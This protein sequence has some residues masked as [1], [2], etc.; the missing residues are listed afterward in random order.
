M[1]D[2]VGRKP[3]AATLR[4][5]EKVRSVF[6]YLLAHLYPA[7]PLPQIQLP[8]SRACGCCLYSASER[9]QC[10]PRPAPAF[11]GKSCPSSSSQSQH[12]SFDWVHIL[13][14]FYTQPKCPPRGSTDENKL[15]LSLKS[16]EMS[17]VL[18]GLQS[19]GKRPCALSSNKLP[20]KGRKRGKA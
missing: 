6:Q 20:M 2:H 14:T 7:F 9:R 15:F 19:I 18:V 12:S 3:M 4:G 13:S 11:P 1:W 16:P 17:C 10:G 8:A 5:K